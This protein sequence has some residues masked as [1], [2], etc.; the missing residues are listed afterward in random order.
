METVKKVKIF[1]VGQA[2]IPILTVDK[3]VWCL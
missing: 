2:K 1:E 3:I